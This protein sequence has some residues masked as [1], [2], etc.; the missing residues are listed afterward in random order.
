MPSHLLSSQISLLGA[1]VRPKGRRRGLSSTRDS[2]GSAGSTVAHLHRPHSL[3]L[4]TLQSKEMGRSWE[5]AGRARQAGVKLINPRRKV[6]TLWQALAPPIHWT[7]ILLYTPRDRGCLS[8]AAGEA[9]ASPQ[10]PGQE[11][12]CPTFPPAKA[13]PHSVKPLGMV[14]AEASPGWD[15]HQLPA[16]SP[17]GNRLRA[18]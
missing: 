8:F 6:G 14:L 15:P 12:Q 7:N 3:W 11:P 18:G 9:L 10:E 16:T 4:L 5:E 2:F 17:K 1:L 13:S